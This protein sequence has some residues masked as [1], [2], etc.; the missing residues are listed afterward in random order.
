MV[1]IYGVT[2]TN[3]T[4]N[5][6]GTA[7]SIKLFGTTISSGIVKLT[8]DGSGTEN[9]TN[10]FSTTINKA[11]NFT[12]NLVATNLPDDSQQTASWFITGYIS[13]GTNSST[14]K[15]KIVSV[16]SSADISMS[17]CEVT[18]QENYAFGGLSITCRGVSQYNEINWV[19]TITGSEV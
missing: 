1:R 19:A 10:I 9:A 2:T 8:L 13:K 5:S 6:G 14:V 3:N 17:D 11:L 12:L 15:Y 7:I 18:L 16:Q 4:Q